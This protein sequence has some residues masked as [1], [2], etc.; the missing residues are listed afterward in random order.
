MG[1]PRAA[2]SPAPGVSIARN[3]HR[4][5]ERN[6]AGAAR[7]VAREPNERG[8]TEI[9][10]DGSD[11]DARLAPRDDIAAGAGKAAGLRVFDLAFPEP[12]RYIF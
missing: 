8:R 10:V 5:G 11:P 7:N 6:F 4:P 9:V 3:V 1:R 12:E 2:A